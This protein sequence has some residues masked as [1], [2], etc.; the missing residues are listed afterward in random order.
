MRSADEFVFSSRMTKG[1]SFDYEHYDVLTGLFTPNANL[2]RS[3]AQQ[4]VRVRSINLKVG[5][6]SIS[7][8]PKRK[9]LYLPL[10][11]HENKK[12]CLSREDFSLNILDD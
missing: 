6:V 3:A 11:L 12:L 8:V 2:P 10:D 7:D 4:L 5:I 1:V 9:N